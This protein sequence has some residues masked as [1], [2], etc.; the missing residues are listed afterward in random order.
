MSYRLYELVDLWKEKAAEYKTKAEISSSDISI[1]L[2]SSY[3]L[4]YN[5]CA[6]SLEKELM[7]VEDELLNTAT[8]SYE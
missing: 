4:V 6:S 8:M 2:N 7:E 1:V 3:S 5:E